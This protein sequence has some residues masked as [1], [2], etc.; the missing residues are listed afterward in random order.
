[1][2][3]NFTKKLWLLVF[4]LIATIS[5][6]GFISCSS[7]GVTASTVVMPD[8]GN[9]FLPPGV[10]GPSDGN[11]NVIITSDLPGFETNKEWANMGTDIPDIPKPPV[12][13]D[14]SL[15][16]IYVPFAGYQ[17]D[18]VTVSYKDQAKLQQIWKEQMTRKGFN[19]GKVFFIKNGKNNKSQDSFKNGND[20]F[21]FDN[22]L[23][24]Y[25]KAHP[26]QRLQNFVGAV[27]VQ[28][29]LGKYKGTYTIG[30][31]YQV[32]GRNNTQPY[33]DLKDD[34]I[35]IFLGRRYAPT[36][37]VLV[38]NTGITRNADSQNYL[39]EEYSVDK[40]LST[41]SQWH[42]VDYEYLKST[43]V[44]DIMD[45]LNSKV[46]LL[47]RTDGGDYIY[48]FVVGDKE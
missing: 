21:Y 38:I 12:E 17:D 23:N 35:D 2:I 40:Y 15:Y 14:G 33:M 25:H 41:T 27:I 45:N 37:E 4:V 46:S 26:N 13:D 11:G 3:K 43:T 20:Y 44:Q 1:M 24:I 31:I 9:G 22:N 42:G 18:S 48:S 29:A 36:I 5:I 7:K 16:K 28:Y 10:T 47:N 6:A 32:I 34:G 30:G 39:K 8:D 19:D